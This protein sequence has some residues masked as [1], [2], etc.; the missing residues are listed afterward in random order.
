MTQSS[1]NYVGH[2]ILE[3]MHEAVRYSEGVFQRLR[4]A[5]PPASRK[6]LDFGAGDGVFVDKFLTRGVAVDCV[7]PDLRLNSHLQG[8]AGAV[9]GDVRDVADAQYDFAYTVNVLEHIEALDEACS[10]L[11]RVIAPNGKLFVFVPAFEV[12]WT[13]LDD[14]VGHFR[15]FT[16]TSLVGALEKSGLVVEHVEYFDSVGFPAALAVR[17]LEKVNLFSYGAGTMGFYDRYLFPVSRR[18]DRVTNGIFGKNLI[19]VARKPA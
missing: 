17:F 9:Y 7:E 15:R 6:V 10:E 14:E 3:A 18:L 19:A 2:R 12:L 1:E 4:E 16:R 13:R 11:F 8:R 5:M